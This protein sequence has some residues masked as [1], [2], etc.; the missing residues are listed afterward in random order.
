MASFS[1]GKGGFFWVPADKAQEAANSGMIPESTDQYMIRQRAKELDNPAM[2]AMGGFVTG[3]T[4][5]LSDL[6]AREKMPVAADETR[7]L[8]EESPW[9]SGAGEV[10]GVIAGILA[11]TNPAG[12]IGGAGQ[13]AARLTAGAVESAAARRI[14]PGVGRALGEGFGMGAGSALSEQSLSGSSLDPVEI[15]KRGARTAALGGVLSLAGTGLESVVGKAWKGLQRTAGVDLEAASQ[16]RAR[17]SDLEAKLAAVRRG[18]TVD[19]KGLDAGKDAFDDL[20]K[21]AFSGARR[22]VE[23]PIQAASPVEEILSAPSAGEAL[24]ADMRAVVAPRVGA[25]SNTINLATASPED[26]LAARYANP[27]AHTPSISYEAELEAR[28]AGYRAQESGAVAHL[29]LG[30]LEKRSAEVADQLGVL[31]AVGQDPERVELAKSILAGL[32]SEASEARTAVFKAAGD[33]L[34]SV[35]APLGFLGL[36]F[37]SWMLGVSGAGM[38]SLLKSSIGKAALGALVESAP[39]IASATGGVVRTAITS[40]ASHDQIDAAQRRSPMATPEEVG[41]AALAGFQ[42]AGLPDRLAQQLAA[43]QAGKTELVGKALGGADSSSGRVSATR[44]LNAVE[45]P[46]RITKRVQDGTA[47]PEDMLVLNKLFPEVGTE[48]KLTA[49]KLLQKGERLTPA[50]RRQLLMIADPAAASAVSGFYQTILSGMAPKPPS[51]PQPAG[52]PSQIAANIA[53]PLEALQG[54]K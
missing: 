15:A 17:I 28:I 40:L 21:K 1:D 11:K 32:K 2:A 43:F 3:V 54:G 42:Q 36:H 51:S 13:S 50:T 25:K 30:I 9:A 12:L 44:I 41:Q 34:S 26:I 27:A 53:T 31:K 48:M 14:L 24:T 37:G 38:G 5:G 19:F 52:K 8:K 20:T 39:G 49:L 29:R 4:G 35:A 7:L 47:Y 23:P 46:R 18:E 33:R 10:A 22:G 45:D 16:A 6:V